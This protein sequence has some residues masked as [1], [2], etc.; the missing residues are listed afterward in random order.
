MPRFRK[1]VRCKVPQCG[2]RRGLAEG[3]DLAHAALFDNHNGTVTDNLTGLIWMKDANGWR[4]QTAAEAVGAA[5]G[6][7]S[8]DYG[9]DGRLQGGRLAA[10]QP[11]GI[12]KPAR[13]WQG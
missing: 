4:E 6:L 2:R 12:S 8:G 13:L 7:K 11:Q 3:R 1:P 10:P 5:N 9:L